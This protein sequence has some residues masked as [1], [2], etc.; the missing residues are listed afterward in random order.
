[1]SI[2]KRVTYLK[3]LAEGLGLGNETKEERILQIIIQ[4]LGE[5][6]IELDELADDITELDDE[7][8]AIIEDVQELEE[9]VSESEEAESACCTSA[10]PATHAMPHP[11]SSPG[12][13]GGRNGNGAK[14]QFYGIKCPSCQSDLTIDEDL[15]KQG[16]VDCPSCNERLE[17]DLED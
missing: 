3:G 12:H 11:V 15:L 5:I 14:S 8:S 13:G 1:M 17:L 7:M 4:V 9:A 2:A 16:V 10:H 6:S